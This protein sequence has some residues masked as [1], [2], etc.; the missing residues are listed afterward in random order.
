MSLV[1]SERDLILSE[2][3][4]VRERLAKVEGMIIEM[5]KRLNHME[6]EMSELRRELRST[7]KWTVGLI[8]GMWVTVIMT[9][10][11]IL[12]KILGLI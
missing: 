4:E 11:P 7:F 12:F 10:M 8:L 9:L 3:A 2:I 1:Y 5:S 6:A